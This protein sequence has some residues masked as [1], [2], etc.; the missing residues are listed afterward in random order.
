DQVELAPLRS[1]DHL[2][3]SGTDIE[4]AGNAVVL[5]PPCDRDPVRRRVPLDLVALALE[6]LRLVLGRT[7]DV[8]DGADGGNRRRRVRRD[9]RPLVHAASP[10]AGG[11]TLRLRCAASGQVAAPD[12]VGISPWSLRAASRSSRSAASPAKASSSS[13]SEALHSSASMN[14]P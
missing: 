8:R 2:L 11:G 12:G 4:H 7:A 6:R 9:R 10:P 5:E 1:R 14:R 13:A 3:E